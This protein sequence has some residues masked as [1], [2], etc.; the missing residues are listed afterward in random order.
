MRNPCLITGGTGTTASRVAKQLAARNLPYRLATRS[1]KGDA[2]IRFDWA[3]S[4][5][6]P[7]A[8]DGVSRIYLVAPS[9]VADPLPA[10]VPF[11]EL[12]VRTGIERF[13][14]LSASSLEEGGL[15]M[16]AVHAWLRGHAPEWV[17]LRPT[18]FMNNFSEKQHLAPIRD[19]GTLYTATDDGRIGFIDAEDI[20][21]VAA[22][23]LS[24]EEFASGDYVLTGPQALS[25]DDVA[26]IMTKALNRAITHKRL[27]VDEL[28]ARHMAFGLPEIYARAL[29]GMDA[30][31]AKGS[32]DR[33]T[34]S[35]EVIAGRKPRS[36]RAFVAANAE[37]WQ[38]K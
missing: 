29:A 21:A 32:E 28:A 12:A 27:T 15:M 18:W 30:A 13:V 23:A 3:D 14:L 7:S 5:T 11:L 24:R 4:E 20:A 6:W 33:V 31:I 38:I 25:Y 17:V 2:D 10:M 36:L 8:L 34:D 19:E 37:A 35:V 9:G 22:E 16:G 26:E 1:P